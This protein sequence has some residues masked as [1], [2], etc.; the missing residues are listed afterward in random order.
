MISFWYQRD[1]GSLHF[2]RLFSSKSL[3][4]IGDIQGAWLEANDGQGGRPLFHPEERRNPRIIPE[5][6]PVSFMII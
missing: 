3:D 2:N 4:D 1:K 5:D 6:K